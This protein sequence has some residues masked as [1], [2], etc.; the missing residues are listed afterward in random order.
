M[1]VMV[2]IFGGV[3][4]KYLELGKYAGLKQAKYDGVEVDKLWR[5]RDVATQITS[6]LITGKSWRKTNIRGRKKYIDSRI[7]YIEKDVIRE[8]IPKHGTIE[9]IERYSRRFREGLYDSIGMSSETRNYIGSDLESTTIFDKVDNSCAIYVPAY[10]PEPSWAVR[11]NILD[12]EVYPELGEKAALDLAEKNFQWRKDKLFTHSG[13][14]YD[15]LVTQFQY[16]DSLQHLYAWYLNDS[17]MIKKGY[18]RIDK[19]AEEIK[20]NFSQYDIILFISDNGVPNPNSNRTHHNR[21]FYSINENKNITETNI[22]DFYRH[23]LNWTKE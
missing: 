12:P 8:H 6:Q 7:Q 13:K 9:K 4:T 14:E 20:A 3:D 19:L 10:N 1:K 2:V 23:I 15:L 21:P 18:A 5:D 22:R 17:E 16:L 11:R